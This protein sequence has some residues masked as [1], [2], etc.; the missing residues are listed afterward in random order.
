[1]THELKWHALGEVLRLELR[2]TIS[3]DEM[4]V[5]NQEIVDI[6]NASE[7]K[8]ILL[9]DVSS[10]KAGYATV[11]SLGATQL[12]RDHGK[13]EAIVAVASNKL[14]RLVT[15]LAFHLSRARFVQF[16][17]LEQAQPYM[18]MIRFTKSN[19]TG[20]QAQNPKQA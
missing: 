18:S 9:L 17:N 5:I 12:Y 10:L 15:M 3:L 11:D 6:L 19:D 16:D 20:Y 13:L 4:R 1:M 7:R 2:D 14:N 8:I